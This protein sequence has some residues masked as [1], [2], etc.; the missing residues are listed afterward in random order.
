MT[1]RRLRLQGAR[2]TC[3]TS[4]EPP[5]SACTR[6]MEGP[7]G[8]ADMSGDQAWGR[9]WPAERLRSGTSLAATCS[10]V[11]YPDQAIAE[12]APTLR[13]ELPTSGPERSRVGPTGARDAAAGTS[14]RSR[15][16]VPRLEEG[17]DPDDPEAEPLQQ[18]PEFAGPR[19]SEDEFRVEALFADV[20]MRRPTNAKP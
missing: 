6:S 15:R 18:S 8:G 17:S 3:G 9:R 14:P 11:R 19:A 4:F 20:W 16:V 12:I 7:L 2:G 10:Q 1:D 13:G 5:T